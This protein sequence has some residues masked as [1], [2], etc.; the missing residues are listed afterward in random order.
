[1]SGLGCLER[2]SE[3]SGLVE[4]PRSKTRRRT[5]DLLRLRSACAG[6]MSVTAA[7]GHSRPKIDPLGCDVDG[8]PHAV[9][10]PEGRLAGAGQFAGPDGEHDRRAAPAADVERRLAVVGQVHVRPCRRPQALL[11]DRREEAGRGDVVEQLGRFER[12][13]AEVDGDRDGVAWR[14]ADSAVGELEALLRRADGGLPGV[15]GGN[16]GRRGPPSRQGARGGR[17]TRRCSA[18]RRQLTDRDATGMTASCSAV[19]RGPPPVAP[20]SGHR[21]RDALFLRSV[22]PRRPAQ[23]APDRLLSGPVARLRW[24]PSARGDSARA[25]SGRRPTRAGCGEALPPPGSG[26]H[27]LRPNGDLLFHLPLASPASRYVQ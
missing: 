25:C 6:C 24:L 17:P 21:P 20:Y 26:G 2:G 10:G 7:A 27:L 18:R 15:L 11:P 8:E 12:D 23:S 3:A 16:P 19:R 5:G 1:L 4:R 13:D 14:G 9:G 22:G